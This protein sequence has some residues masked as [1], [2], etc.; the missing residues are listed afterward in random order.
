MPDGTHCFV[1]ANIF[2]YHLVNTPPLSDACSNFFERM[3][4]R[5]VAGCSSVVAMAEAVHKVMLAEAVARYGLEP[6]ALAHRLQQRSEL[7]AGLSEHHKVVAL[8]RAL[9]I[10]AEA[11]TLALMERAAH[12]S[13]QHRL[14]TNDALI[15]AVM[16]KLDVTHLA[17]ND[18]N[19]DSVPDITVW[20]PR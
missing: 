3:E 11:V 19:F 6:R 15:L 14:L 13:T 5:E 9:N 7:I 8:V 16:E 4:R 17:T 18:D 1:D 10:H 20:K 2:C 12:L